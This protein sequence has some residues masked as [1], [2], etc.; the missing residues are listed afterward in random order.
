MFVHCA[1][2]GASLSPHFKSDNMAKGR[3]GGTKAKITGQVGNNIFQ[4][5]KNGNGTYTQISYVKGV[6]TE[7]ETSEKLQVQR[8]VTC[9][10]ESLM[11][12]IK[13]VTQLSMQAGKNKTNS[14]NAFSSMNLR[15]VAADCK[16]NWYESQ[17]FVYPLP[18]REWGKTKDLGG[19]YR[20]SSGTGSINHF[21]RCFHTATPQLLMEDWSNP[22]AN[23]VGLEFLIPD[24]CATIGD[25]LRKGKITRLDMVVLCAFHFWLEDDP[26][27]GEG[28]WLSRHE[29]V[30]MRLNSSV[31]DNSDLNIDSLRALFTMQHGEAVPQLYWGKDNKSFYLGYQ[32]DLM[33]DDNYYYGGAFTISYLTGKKLITDSHYDWLTYVHEP[34]LRSQNPADVFGYWMGTPQ[35]DPYP[36]P[37]NPPLYRFI[38]YVKRNGSLSM[39]I[40]YYFIARNQT[41]E[42]DFDRNVSRVGYVISNNTTVAGSL[43]V[44][45]NASFTNITAFLITSV[46][47]IE[48]QSLISTNDLDRH[49]IKISGSNGIIS[50]FV[51]DELIEVKDLASLMPSTTSLPLLINL[52]T[53]SGAECKLYGLRIYDTATGEMRVNLRPA[54]RL[55]DLKYGLYDEVRDIFFTDPAFTGG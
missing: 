28:N 47:S 6:R 16:A 52:G 34:W 41:I 45:S 43:F 37:F 48:R 8:M 35:I 44:F 10:V 23:F 29:Y 49:C 13:P 36:D 15:Y 3:V 4:I 21:S 5:R 50:Y 14:M 38:D 42:L 31:S 54:I 20:L 2:L 32:E 39:S 18:S 55:T 46:P 19:L 33:Q 25:Y 12:D 9:M 17:E 53:V 26:E 27:S 22:N 30:I 40:E 24:G 11:R 1:G 7:T 51:D